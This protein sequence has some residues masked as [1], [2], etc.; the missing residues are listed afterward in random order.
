MKNILLI[1]VLLL[2]FSACKKEADKPQAKSINVKFYSSNMITAAKIITVQVDGVKK[3]R[4]S[5]SATAPGC[6]AS[7]FTSLMLD[8]GTYYVE[9]LDVE[10]I[11]VS[12]SVNIPQSSNGCVFFNLK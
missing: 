1:S 3:G 8:P 6:G 10:K 12:M 7:G 4:L 9:M 2:A 5:Y 11:I